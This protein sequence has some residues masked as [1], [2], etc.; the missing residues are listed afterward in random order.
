MSFCFDFPQQLRHAVDASRSAL[1]GSRAV[2]RLWDKD[3][4]LW[5]A[6]PLEI[7]DRLGWLTVI[8][9]M[10]GQ[11]SSLTSF[12][13]SIRDRGMR[14]VVLLGMGGSSLGPEVLRASF[15]SSKGH[16]RL[17]VLDSTVPGWVQSVTSAVHPLKTL[18]IVASKSG[19]TIEVM[20]L[21]AHFWELTRKKAGHR[22]GEQFIAITDPGTGL[23]KLAAERQFW[24]IFTNPPDIGG[25]YSVLSYFGLV[26]A[27]LLGLDLDKLLARAADM[28]AQCREHHAV[29][30][31]PGVELG[32]AMAALARA[33]RDKVTLM[34]SPA[35]TSF[36]LWAEQL[37]AESTGKEG[38][39]LIP[40]AE[41][42]IVSAEAYG[43]DRFF[44]YLRLSGDHNRELDRQIERLKKQ[45]HPVMTINLRDCY[46]LG[47]EFFRWEFATAI[48][49][50]LLGIHPFDQPNVQ[51]SKDNTKRV[52]SELQRNGALPAESSDTVTRVAAQLKRLS[53]PGTYV[54]MLVYATPSPA[55][56]RAVHALRKTLIS[57]QQVTTT[58]GYGPRYLH[59]TGQLHKGGPDTGVFLQL[60]EQMQPDLPIPGE[61]ITFGI[62]ARAQA[63][64]DI[65]ALR[66]HQRN[67]IA[68]SL[69]RRPSVTLGRL[70]R[71]LAPPARGRAVS[72]RARR[73]SRHK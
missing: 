41:E 37:L 30:R 45:A 1:T 13:R 68:V 18:F 21:L 35:I 48:A 58:A 64:G 71:A 44:V 54:A 28:A 57:R 29:E 51:E 40:V 47:S 59:S 63:T 9:E 42:P 4:T 70:K 23:E 25:R 16:P 38:T 10:Q 69:G 60:I 31:N 46:D 43:Q 3:Y 24:R 73:R 66:A 20:S 49:G 5:K 72:S 6:E 19:G 7:V 55:V 11:V 34:A 50:H 39:G 2:Q 52:L 8:R 33:G 62:L 27:A 32:A 14:D 17:W 61:P 12:S 15:G 26:P 67:V 56:E 53:R 36:G 22:V 65:Q